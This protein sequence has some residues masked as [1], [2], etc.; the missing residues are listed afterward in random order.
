MSKLAQACELSFNEWIE[1]FPEVMPVAERSPKH[2]KWKK[3]L[4]NKM[5]N[6]RYHV[7]TTKSVKILLIAAILCALLMSAFVF[8]SSR[9]ALTDNFDIFSTFKMTKDNNN[10]INS[11][12]IVGYIPEGY[13]LI[14]ELDN[15]KYKL[16]KYSNNKG[17]FFTIMKQSS[18]IKVNYNSEE[19]V[20]SEIIFNNVKYICSTGDLGA[21]NIVWTKNDYVYQIESSLS[22]DEIIKI[23]ESI[24]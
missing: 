6:D 4:F 1:T 2:E 9:E 13:E 15:G 11:D 16:Y 22:M 20:S 18:S 23:A 21:S 12:I 24:E 10:Y 19:Q 8:P 5:R 17:L 3:Q 7:L 14:N